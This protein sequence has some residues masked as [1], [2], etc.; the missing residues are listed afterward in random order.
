MTETEQNFGARVRA[1][2]LER[3]L[4]QREVCEAVR[5]LTERQLNRIESGES[6]PRLDLAQRLSRVLGVSL[7]AMPSGL[8][9]QQK[10]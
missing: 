4:T 7:D 5:P 2:R 6:I 10:E 3:G 8:D 1:A 9:S